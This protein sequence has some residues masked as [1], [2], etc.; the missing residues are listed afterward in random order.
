MTDTDTA[1]EDAATEDTATEGTEDTDAAT[2]GDE[3]PDDAET[4]PRSVVEKLRQENGRYRQRAAQADAYA[5]R[6]HAALVAATGRLADPADLPFDAE[7]LDDPDALTAALDALLTDKPH[8]ASRKPSG[9]IGQGN[10]GPASGS[11][12]LLDTLKSLT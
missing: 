8:L 12:S 6:L 5:Q 9:D 4:F 1:T 2:E 10:R 7:H 3:Q 11:F